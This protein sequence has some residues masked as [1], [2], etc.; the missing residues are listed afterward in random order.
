[1]KSDEGSIFVV[2]TCSSSSIIGKVRVKTL[3]IPTD[4]DKE[5]FLSS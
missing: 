1:M 4:Y 5:K 3:L 2:T